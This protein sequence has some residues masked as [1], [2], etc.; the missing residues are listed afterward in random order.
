MPDEELEEVLETF[1]DYG[2]TSSTALSPTSEFY[3][4]I[5]GSSGSRMALSEYQRAAELVM[6]PG[7]VQDE[8]MFSAMKYLKNPQQ[9]K[10][11]THLTAC[12]RLFRDKAFTAESF[13]FAAA[14]TSRDAKCTMRV[15]T[16]RV[17]L[18]SDLMECRV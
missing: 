13:P 5:N 16:S 14:I 8:C 6:V 10:L 4:S 3:S 2:S 9:N 15:L 1:Y 17:C 11:S 12:A 18:S 7:L